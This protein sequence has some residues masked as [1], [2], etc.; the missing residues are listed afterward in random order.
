M[1]IYAW[2]M[3]FMTVKVLT[4]Q[5]PVVTVCTPSLTFSNPTFCPHSVFMCFVWI[6][7]QT[8]TIWRNNT[9]S[10]IENQTQTQGKLLILTFPIYIYIYIYI[11]T[12][13]HMR[14]CFSVCVTFPSLPYVIHSTAAVRHAPFRRSRTASNP[15]SKF[16]TSLPSIK[17]VLHKVCRTSR[18]SARVVLGKECDSDIPL[19]GPPQHVALSAA[20]HHLH[21]ASRPLAHSATWRNALPANIADSRT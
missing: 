11:H 21:T 8:A 14:A 12:H 15:H 6:W 16:A 5:S 7:E 19:G 18:C 13:T 10:A 1:S 3:S 9:G 20:R 4:L 2:R 17:D